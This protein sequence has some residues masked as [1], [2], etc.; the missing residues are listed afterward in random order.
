M[1]DFVYQNSEKMDSFFS[2]LGRTRIC[3]T[4]EDNVTLSKLCKNFINFTEM[5]GYSTTSWENLIMELSKKIES[6]ERLLDWIY[7]ED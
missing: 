6:G 7:D 2:H 5:V 3:T 4:V 1:I